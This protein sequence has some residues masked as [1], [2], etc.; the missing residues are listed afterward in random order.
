MRRAR[1][2]DANQRAIVEALRAVGAVVEVLSDVGR[3]VPDLLVG[4]RERWHLIECKRPGPPHA[5][6]LTDDEERW[7]ARARAHHLPVYVA[8]DGQEAIDAMS[9]WVK[10][11]GPHQG[12]APSSSTAGSSSRQS[13]S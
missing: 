13:G 1:R 2:T 8:Q 5:R 4:W 3:G 7:H 6:K 11:T 12:S 10:R 9:R